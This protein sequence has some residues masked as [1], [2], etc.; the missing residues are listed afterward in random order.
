MAS[1]TA[2]AAWAWAPIAMDMTNTAVFRVS[3]MSRDIKKSF[4]GK[5]A[6]HGLTADMRVQA[7]LREACRYDISRLTRIVKISGGLII[8]VH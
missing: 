7:S 6:R 4:V 5:P 1:V 3:V 2:S 8:D